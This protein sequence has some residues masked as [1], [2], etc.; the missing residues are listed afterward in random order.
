MHNVILLTTL[1]IKL[2]FYGHEIK[3][4]RVSMVICFYPAGSVAQV[5]DSADKKLDLSR[6][7]DL[8]LSIREQENE[9]LRC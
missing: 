7:V 1:R 9:W 4:K 3:V 6:V 8:S 5:E 2:R